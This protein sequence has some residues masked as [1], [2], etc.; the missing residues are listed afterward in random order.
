[1][2]VT[3]T[4]KILY[5]LGLTGLGCG[6]A[7]ALFLRSGALDFVHDLD[8]CVFHRVTGLYCPGCGITR[9]CFALANGH[10]IR[11]ILLHPVPVYLTGLYLVWMGYMTVRLIKERSLCGAPAEQRQAKLQKNRRFYRRFEKAVYVMAGLLILQWIVK[12]LLQLL[13]GLDWFALISRI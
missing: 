12:L 13:F 1:M 6:V 4:E 7:G 11:S 2:K 5:I 8:L 9:A 3:K 10:V